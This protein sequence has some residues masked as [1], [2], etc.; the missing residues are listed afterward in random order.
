MSVLELAAYDGIVQMF[1]DQP[2]LRVRYG[3]EILGPQVLGRLEEQE[4]FFLAS[5]HPSCYYI[6]VKLCQH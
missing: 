4:V 6:F 2:V 3:H 5:T 1:E